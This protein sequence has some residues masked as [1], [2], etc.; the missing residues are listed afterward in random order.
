M[1]GNQKTKQLLT[2]AR[3][4]GFD[5]VTLTRAATAA[6]FSAFQCWLDAG[7]HGEMEYLQ[8]HSDARRHPSSVLPEVKTVFVVALAYEK[9][10]PLRCSQKT[11]AALATTSDCGIIAEYARGLDYHNVMRAKLQQLAETHHALFPDAKTR[12][13]VDTA[14]ILEREYAARAGIGWPGKNTMLI[15]EP[16]GSRFFLGLLLSTI[17]LDDMAPVEQTASVFESPEQNSFCGNC[18]RCIDACPTGALSPYQL[19][20]RKCLNYWSIEYRGDDIPAEI[21][22]EFGKRL[23]G[24]ETCQSICPFN[25]TK[26]H[27]V[28]QKTNGCACCPGHEKFRPTETKP[29]VPQ[30]SQHIDLQTLTLR[31]QLELGVM[32]LSQIESLD[33]S[34]FQREFS[35][36]PLERLGLIRLKRNAVIVRRNI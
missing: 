23:F 21:A 7:M 4:I 15:N 13:A 5:A 31:E 16:C 11:L 22:A 32:S 6:T 10:N 29:G 35:G 3:E 17:E 27:D 8:R 25:Q 1:T 34:A 26:S 18:R 36:T 12:I 2:Q 33:E 9:V 28:S 24:C 20:A 19:D 30:A 14:P